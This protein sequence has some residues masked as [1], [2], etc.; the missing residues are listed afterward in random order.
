MRCVATARSYQPIPFWVKSAK[1]NAEKE[2]KIGG[3]ATY[4]GGVSD[5]PVITPCTDIA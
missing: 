1:E 3:Y 2:P 5:V 4:R